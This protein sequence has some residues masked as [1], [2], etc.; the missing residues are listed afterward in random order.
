MS[1]FCLGGFAHQS[2]IVVHSWDGKAGSSRSGSEAPTVAGVGRTIH[3]IGH[4]VGLM[5]EHQR[6]DRDTYV[7]V[8]DAN[9]YGGIR[10]AYLAD[11]P[12]TRPYDYS[13]IMHYHSVGTIP[14]GIPVRSDRLSSGDID[15]VARLYGTVPTATT[16][17]T[18]PAGLVIL[19]DG[20]SVRTPAQFDWSPG[21]THTL[22]AIS[23]Q[24]VGAER[25]VFGRWSD[26]GSSRRTVT[27]DSKSTWFAANYIAQR[28]VLSCAEPSEAGSVTVHPESRDGFHVQRQPVEVEAKADG[29]INFLEWNP[30]PALRRGANRR[31]RV[32]SPGASSN[33]A[34]GATPIWSNWSSHGTGITE[35]AAVYTAKPTFLVD[36]N[37]DGIRILLGR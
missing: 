12:G 27:A 32:S 10:F 16:I 23:P 8:S 9:S 20:E 36:S 1:D 31:S 13:S 5:H 3:E 18:N 2:L 21:S 17:T 29:P 25:F 19:V 4:A 15:G 35:F 11:T 28:R 26:D 6:H 7:T 24:T 14:P 30:D 34:S 22:Q 33:P 37:V